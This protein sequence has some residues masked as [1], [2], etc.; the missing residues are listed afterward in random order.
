MGSKYQAEQRVEHVAIACSPDMIKPTPKD[1][2]LPFIT[3]A[4]FD[5]AVNVADQTKGNQHPAF[6]SVSKVPHC[7]G[8][9]PG[10]KG[11]KSGTWNGEF[12]PTQWSNTVQTGPGWQVYHGHKG[13][14][15]N[16]NTDAE[17]MT[18]V[19]S[20]APSSPCIAGLKAQFERTKR[21]A[22]AEFQSDPWQFSKD[23]AGGAWDTIKG[24]GEA[25][26][27]IWDGVKSVAGA[28][29]DDP[30]G[31]A[32]R[33]A[34]AVGNAA[35]SAVGAVKQVADLGMAM[36]GQELSIDDMLDGLEDLFSEIGE[37]AACALAK[38]LQETNDASG[39]VAEAVG[40]ITCE[41]AIQIGL[42]LAT[43]GAGNAASAG[44]KA[45]KAGK[46]ADKGLDVL[47]GAGA[48]L[49][50]M[51]IKEG[52]DLKTIFKRLKER[53]ATG[54]GNSPDRTPARTEHNPEPAAGGNKS[55]T[56]NKGQ[57]DGD[58]N[59]PCPV[60]P[61]VGN[62]VNPVQGCKVLSGDEDLDFVLPGLVPLHW[63]RS[64]AS[65]NAGA[66]WFGQGWSVPFTLQ[67]RVKERGEAIDF[68]DAF[69]RVIAFP[70]VALGREFFSA[71]EAISLRRDGPMAYSIVASDGSR[72]VFDQPSG[73]LLMCGALE[74][75]QGR[76]H[77]V[78]Y[79]P[80]AQAGEP[81]EPRHVLAQGGQVL[82]LVFG[83]C[84]QHGGEPARRLLEVRQLGDASGSDTNPLRPHID[85]QAPFEERWQQL[86]QWLS[87]G[88]VGANAPGQ[89]L[90]RYAYS[91]DGDLLTVHTPDANGAMAATP[92]RRFG[93]QQ[94]LLVRHDQPEGWIS[95]YAYDRLDA[96]G[97]V[98][99]HWQ[100]I[101]QPA[102]D[103]VQQVRLEWQ[104]E[105]TSSSTRVVQAPGTADA[106]VETYHFDDRLRWTGTTNAL[107]QRTTFVLNDQGNIQ[108]V[109]DPAGRRTRHVLDGRGRPT[110]IINANGERTSIRWHDTLE[111]PLEITD[112][113]GGSERFELDAFG[114][115]LAST[116]ALGRCTR[117]VVDARG[118]AAEI[119]D[120]KGGITRLQHDDWGQLT[121]YTDC[122]GHSTQLGYD[123]WGQLASSRNALGQITHYRHD[124]QGRLLSVQQPDG[125]QE[126]FSYDGAGRL[127]QHTDA[128]GHVTRWELAADGLPLRRVNALGQ[129]L[130]YRYDIHRRLASLVNENGDRYGFSY[131]TLD[132]LIE[133]QTFD[134]KRT[135]YQYDPAGQL[136]QALEL[137]DSSA[138]EADRIET[139]FERDAVGRLLAK[140]LKTPGRPL[141]ATRFGYDG[142]GALIQ[143]SNAH[144]RVA[145]HYDAAGQL[146]EEQLTAPGL[147]PAAL[148][149]P[150][151]G[152][153]RQH[154]LRHRYDELGNR[155][156]TTLPD[157]RVLNTLVYGS[158][159]VH[160]F[161]V[162]GQIISDVERDAL[163][164]EVTR[165]QGLLRSTR[166]YDVMGRLQ[167]QQVQRVTAP[168]A[169]VA[170]PVGA[171][172]GRTARDG[173]AIQ[174]LYRYDAAGQLS[175]MQDWRHSV[176]YGY[177]PLGQLLSADEERFAF[178]PAHNLL[179]GSAT[180]RSGAQGS[181]GRVERN[182]LLVFE[183]QR[184]SYDAHGRMATKRSG[185]HRALQ[186]HWNAE[187]QLERSVLQHQGQPTVTTGYAYDP[188]GRR[189]YKAPLVAQGQVIAQ[190]A[191]WFVWDGNRLLQE[192]KTL[193]DD[194]ST[195]AR[196]LTQTYVYEPDT[197]VPLAQLRT[198]ASLAE[199]A[200]QPLKP[201]RLRVGRDAAAAAS[202][203]TASANESAHEPA[204]VRYYHCDQIGTPRELTASDGHITWQ[205]TYRAWG[206]TQTVQWEAP[207]HL[208]AHGEAANAA[209]WHDE[210]PDR[211]ELQPLRFQGQYFDVETGLHYNRFRYYDPGA[212]RFVSQDPIGLAGGDNEY[213]FVVDPISWFDASGLSSAKLNSALGGTVGDSR[214]A[215]H[216]IPEE[217]WSKKQGFLDKLGLGRDANQN[218]ILMPD[219]SSEA[220]NQ[221]RRAYHCGS[222]AN[223]SAM[224]EGKLT[225]IEDRF[226]QG[227][228]SLE[229]AHTEV[230]SL[231]RSLFRK[232]STGKI[233]TKRPCGRL[234]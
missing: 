22:A 109:I 94:H 9:P 224:V 66:A 210:Q 8:G 92:R 73:S 216:L 12:V 26:G 138:S 45:A 52:D 2:P 195:A 71:S 72:L 231:Q 7:K 113:L 18:L 11:I 121:Q 106:R 54:K 117:F 19:G 23:M 158:G 104:F 44:A 130:Q 118:L 220:A 185:A 123:A 64:Y 214:Q 131:D 150:L 48:K 187:H 181:A 89:A 6:V 90:V 25:A 140:L 212:G 42:A 189:L 209:T 147:V 35:S 155:V 172:Q 133:E 173:A 225:A 232:I 218:G 30:L 159:H 182:R 102:T 207:P 84:G 34:E 200:A 135:Q 191:T 91:S 165:S 156:A 39:G 127:V 160:Q 188:F 79:N 101:A 55:D 14:I 116:D 203:V 149:I 122:S 166:Q 148:R 57:G 126:L 204:Q 21:K 15:N 226:N 111:R 16:G 110:Q 221:G 24:Y 179:P 62:P 60:C 5:T 28:I 141:S 205:A 124:R 157:G 201:L 223:Y 136:L 125:S 112:P 186:L 53:R 183:D 56:H 194:S 139:R 83:V 202:S 65:N 63:Q 49:K 199:P 161:N 169:A 47:A 31:S 152:G 36:I 99:R 197:F 178:D 222:H 69:G 163:H 93:W 134:G 50:A 180:P 132:R 75:A 229:R 61:T 78:F 95:H 68:I 100:D 192:L 145:L 20:G 119:H 128:A 146:I 32:Q 144:C 143:A 88:K 82:A 74:D 176:S 170:A 213:C 29:W 206:N 215:H 154:T 3:Y 86:N 208:D 171:R 198:E 211:S 168:A 1:P 46:Y 153:G 233:S 43:G 108:A 17:V 228:I 129:P 184:F 107:G 190:D 230:R 219:S 164:R 234:H 193:S 151:Q 114:N 41:A 80:P 85:P 27:S 51:G 175:Q 13:T 196:S 105:Y 58:A 76:A 33:A 81:P 174:R 96:E 167:A 10:G 98:L 120:A 103:R 177:D 40:G 115:L 77:R 97:K 142:K 87:T 37:E 217:I 70:G 137:G 162:D 227:L 4:E 59:R 67:L 38:M